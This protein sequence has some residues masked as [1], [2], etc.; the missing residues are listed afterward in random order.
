MHPAYAR[1]LMVGYEPLGDLFHD[2]VTF[3]L[4]SMGDIRVDLSGPS[5]ESGVLCRLLSIL[6]LV[7]AWPVRNFAAVAALVGAQ[8]SIMRPVDSR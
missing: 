2:H 8:V 3:E 4:G 7:T 6:L 1:F 5:S